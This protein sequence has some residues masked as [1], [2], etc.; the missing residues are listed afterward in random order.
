MN[1]NDFLLWLSAKGS[2]TW[3]R[4]RGTID[5]M[6]ATD[7]P[8]GEGDDID[9]VSGIEDLPVHH[10]IRLNLERLGHVE[11]FRREFPNGW[12]VVPPTLSCRTYHNAAVGILCGARTDQLLARIK[13]ATADLRI[14]VTSQ[15]ECPDRIE[16][17]ASE[18]QQLKQLTHD[19]GLYFQ[20]EAARMLLAAIPPVDDWQLRAPAEFPFGDDWEVTRF[21]AQRLEWIAT[22]PSG[23]RS[24]SF[25]LFRFQMGYQPQ[26][27][28]QFRGR[29][30]KISVQ[31]G[32][33]IV[34]RKARRRV[35]SHDT[36]HQIFA[37]PVSCR[38]PLLV[39]RALTLCEGLIPG[40][41]SARLIYQNV[42]KP[43]AQ[44][45]AALLRQ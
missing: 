16:I 30:Y 43:I 22:T 17:I 15:L 32:K 40:I 36:V 44:T 31:V 14:N 34:L 3:S 37:V 10:R 11:F 41:E 25:G 27:Y 33:Y 42:S 9:D 21:S 18:Q 29:A 35:I 23:A 1:V 12:R 2:G 45:T 19:C 24:A 4:Y 28:L 8:N 13:D 7:E 39:D 20:P 5:E 38:P 26:Y 6:V